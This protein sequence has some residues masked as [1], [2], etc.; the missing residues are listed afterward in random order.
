MSELQLYVTAGPAV[1]QS[2]MATYHLDEICPPGRDSRE[3]MFVD[4]MVITSRAPPIKQ[5]QR[6]TLTDG[7]AVSREDVPGGRGF[8]KDKLLALL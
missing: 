2:A 1:S 3:S 5:G 6:T 7:R 4:A 8:G